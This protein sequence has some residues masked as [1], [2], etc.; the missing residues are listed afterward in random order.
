LIPTITADPRITSSEKPY[1]EAEKI[2]NELKLKLDKVTTKQEALVLINEAIVDLNKYGL[3]PKGMSVR[4]A[5]R[6]VTVCF[7]KSELL[8]PTQKSNLNNTGNINCLVVG[9]ATETYFRPYPSLVMDIPIIEYL[10][11][12]SNFSKYFNFLAWFY[13]IRVFTPVKFGPYAYVGN[14]YKAF[15]DGNLTDKIYSSSGFVWTIGANGIKKWNGSFY[16]GLYT[17]YM[18]AVYENNSYEIWDAVGIR[19]FVGINFFNCISF[20]SSNEFPSFYIGFAR[21]INFTYNPPWT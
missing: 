3:L 1:V 11:F 13:A 2:F 19:C 5:Q 7:L 9:I 14:R 18:K 4:Q 15:E 17:K 12:D 6:L 8:Q 16:G 10:V 21:E 20:A